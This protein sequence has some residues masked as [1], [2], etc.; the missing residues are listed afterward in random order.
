MKKAL[1]DTNILSYF[2]RGKIEVV[3]KL[4]E[5]SQFYEYLTFS[6]LSYYEIKSGLLYKD[7]KNLLSKFEE[8][9]NESEILPLTVKTM[10]IASKIY[11]ELRTKGLLIPPIDILIAASSIECGYLLVTANTKHFEN[12][13]DLTVE[14][15]AE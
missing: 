7:A 5:Y 9:A 12:I 15:W 11:V 1:L 10:N 8:L 6:I 3:T 2:L 4:N 13:S 14:N